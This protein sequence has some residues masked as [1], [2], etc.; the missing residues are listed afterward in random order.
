MRNLGIKKREWADTLNNNVIEL[1]EDVDK[2]MNKNT[3]EEYMMIN[4]K[5]QEWLEQRNI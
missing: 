5:H 2:I 1:K 3:C 4:K